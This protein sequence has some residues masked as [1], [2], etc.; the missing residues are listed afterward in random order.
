MWRK[1]RCTFPFSRN[2]DGAIP[3]GDAEI[4]AVLRN[5]VVGGI[6]ILVGSVRAAAELSPEVLLDCSGKEDGLAVD[7]VQ[8]GPASGRLRS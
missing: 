6:A 2:V 1:M 5:G 3:P 8:R 7:F 4:G